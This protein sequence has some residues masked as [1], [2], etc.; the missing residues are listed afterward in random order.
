VR[1]RI[2]SSYAGIISKSFKV[3]P[4]K[5]HSLLMLVHLQFHMSY[6]YSNFFFHPHF[7]QNLGP[8]CSV[9]VL[10]G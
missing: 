2:E 9:W 3:P 4:P 1:T 5:L 7:W 6:F 10:Y 8:V